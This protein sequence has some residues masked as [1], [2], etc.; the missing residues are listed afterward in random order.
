V[1]GQPSALWWPAADARRLTESWAAPQ[2]AA[3]REAERRAATEALLREV[4]REL[5]GCGGRPERAGLP[6][7]QGSGRA[8]SV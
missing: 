1:L 5:T 3:K 8:G 4:E 2:R 6:L 7:H